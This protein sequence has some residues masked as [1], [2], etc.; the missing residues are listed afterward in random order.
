M[1][2]I[3]AP[4][5]VQDRIGYEGD[6][7]CNINIES[8]RH[9][10]GIKTYRFQLTTTSRYSKK[11]KLQSTLVS[12]YTNRTLA[13]TWSWESMHKTWYW[14]TQSSCLYL[15]H[16][17]FGAFDHRKYRTNIIFTSSDVANSAF[18]RRTLCVVL[19]YA[20]AKMLPTPKEKKKCFAPQGKKTKQSVARGETLPHP[21]PPLL[22][23]HC[24]QVVYRQLNMLYASPISSHV[25]IKRAINT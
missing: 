16:Y 13:F 18:P 1:I 14:T 9:R 20:Q 12:A 5:N 15:P 11:A 19:L 21:N 3:L 22:Q 8:Y 17:T 10:S 7:Q 4:R 6:T 25:I 23:S 24:L 2:N